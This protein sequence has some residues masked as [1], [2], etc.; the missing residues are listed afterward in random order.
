M[1]STCVQTFMF[2]KASTFLG[3]YIYKNKEY[4]PLN[5]KIVSYII[6]FHSFQLLMKCS[7]FHKT[8]KS[9]GSLI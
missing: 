9:L 4:I 6:F 8:H 2:I 3:L 7:S 1:E 5:W